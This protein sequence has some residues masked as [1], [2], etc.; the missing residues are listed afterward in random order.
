VPNASSVTLASD[1][2][3]PAD[4]PLN[5]RAVPVTHVEAEFARVSR[6]AEYLA[7]WDGGQIAPWLYT[8]LDE[9]DNGVQN[10][11]QGVQ[12]L[13]QGR[14]LAVSGSDWR[15]PMSHVFIIKM[16]SRSRVG[17][18]R[19][20]TFASNDPPPD[21]TIVKTIGIDTVMWHAGGMD[22]LGDILAVPVE[23]AP[24]G[25]LR[26]LAALPL[27]DHGK[28]SRSRVLFF[29]MKNPAKP[30]LFRCTIERPGDTAGSVALTRLPNR[31]YLVAV[32]VGVRIDFYLSKTQKFADG[33]RDTPSTWEGREMRVAGDLKREIGG[34]QAINFINQR[35]GQLYLAGLHNT[36]GGAP[37]FGGDDIM[38]LLTVDI[39]GASTSPKN[40][41]ESVAVP[42]ITRVASRKFECKHRQCNMDGAAGVYVDRGKL[43]VYSTYHWRTGKGVVKFNEFR[44]PTKP[45]MNMV[46]KPEDGW[47]ELFEKTYFSGRFL[48]ITSTKDSSIADYGKIRA[49]GSGFNDKVSSVKFQLPTGATYRLFK[50]KDF[51]GKLIDLVGTGKVE[52]IADFKAGKIER[53]VSSSRFTSGG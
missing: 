51:K 1:L 22:V 42:V 8:M 46:T 43:I 15:T 39:P 34:Y 37:T 6:R 21:D 28:V 48:T 16:Q 26:G 40:S 30:A 19:T 32:M 13:R 10:H 33:F 11:F 25:I 44:P 4:T 50:D 47:I 29:H 41:H 49:Q 35:D 36:S 27:P 20:N 5:D 38:D 7:A 18:W 53:K 3:E 24:P 52:E 2:P 12:R 17:P 31:H 45:T 9:N 14:F 23:Y